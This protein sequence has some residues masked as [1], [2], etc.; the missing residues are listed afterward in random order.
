MQPVAH[1]IYYGGTLTYA[2]TLYNFE[3]AIAGIDNNMCESL[4]NMHNN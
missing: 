4:L 1:A 3:K 2:G